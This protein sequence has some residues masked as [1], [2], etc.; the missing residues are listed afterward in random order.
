MTRIPGVPVAATA[1]CTAVTAAAPGASLVRARRTVFDRLDGP[2]PAPIE[3]SVFGF[4]RAD[5]STNPGGT[6]H[7][8]FR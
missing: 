8:A 1:V 3:S 2:R 6:M 4:S 5:P 7:S